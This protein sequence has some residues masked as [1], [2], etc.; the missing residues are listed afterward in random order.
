MSARHLCHASTSL[1]SPRTHLHS[2]VWV[3]HTSVSATCDYF[4]RVSLFFVVFH[5]RGYF[6]SSFKQRAL[7]LRI[8]SHLALYIS[9]YLSFSFVRALRVVNVRWRFSL[10]FGFGTD[11]NA[12]SGHTS[13]PI[14]FLLSDACLCRAASPYCLGND[15]MLEDGPS[16]SEHS[17]TSATVVRDDPILASNTV[18]QQ[19]LLRRVLC[20]FDMYSILPKRS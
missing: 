3:I 5:A 8:L 19:L 7:V 2:A 15:L 9:R 6:F 11:R 12:S 17:P 14:S 1:S 20:E 4:S 13:S 10:A 16:S 18:H